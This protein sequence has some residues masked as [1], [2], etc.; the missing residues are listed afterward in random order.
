MRKI[1]TIFIVAVVLM[2]SSCN[3][4]KFYVAGEPGTV[5]TSLGG[6][7]TLAIIDQSGVAKIELN[8]KKGYV[9]FLQAKAPNSNNFIPFAL[10][11]KDFDRSTLNTIV[12]GVLFMP[13]FIG[14]LGPSWILLERRGIAYDYKYLNYQHTNNDLI[15]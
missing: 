8:R 13:L 6:S 4:Q 11:Y 9:A 7:E 15:Q 10:D 14:F 5:I 1:I 2:N 3:T 12:G